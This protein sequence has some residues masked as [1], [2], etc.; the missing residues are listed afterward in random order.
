MM[1]S[2]SLQMTAEEF[3]VFEP[4]ALACIDCGRDALAKGNYDY[5][6]SGLTLEGMLPALKRG[7]IV[8]IGG[9]EFLALYHGVWCRLDGCSPE[10]KAVLDAVMER[11]MESEEVVSQTIKAG[12]K[13]YVAYGAR[14]RQSGGS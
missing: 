1:L 4:L 6:S 13:P 11:M 7:E 5:E 12:Q 3:A 9:R 10:D 2:H 8:E 14:K